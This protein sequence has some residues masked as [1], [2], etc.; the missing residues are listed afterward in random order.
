MPLQHL[1]GT[2]YLGSEVASKLFQGSLKDLI[3]FTK[4]LDESE[5]K[6]IYDIKNDKNIKS[7]KTNEVF[8]LYY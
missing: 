7:F 3:F 4:A 2:I 6:R 8:L 5:I 1:D